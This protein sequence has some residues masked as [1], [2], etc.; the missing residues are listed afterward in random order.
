MQVAYWT[1]KVA[2]AFGFVPERRIFMFQN[3]F[4]LPDKRK[5]V[6]YYAL[7]LVLTL[8]ITAGIFAKNGWFPST[9]AISGKRTGWF[10]QTVAKNAPSSWNPLPLTTPTPGPPLAKEY[11]YAGSRLLA[12]EDANAT[13]VPPA[14]LAIFRPTG[15]EW[16]ILDGSASGSYSTYGALSWGLSGD[17]PV[18]GDYDGDGKTDFTIFRPSN[19][20]FWV[21]RSSEIATGG[22]MSESMGLTGDFPVSADVDGDGKTDFVLWRPSDSTWTIKQSSDGSTSYFG[23]ETGDKPAAGDF[24]GD[25][26]SD[27]AVW[28]DSNKTFYSRN[29]SNGATS[30]FT[31]TQSSTEPV[32]ADYDGDGK[33]DYAIRE[34]GTSNWVIRY[35]GSNTTSTISWQNASD[36]AV[37]N[38]YDGDGK[39]DIATWRDSNG[40]WY[41]RPSANPTTTRTVA[42]GMSG[43]WPVP[44]YFRR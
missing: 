34:S 25:G 22:H 3:E 15:A 28:R 5:K 43:D 33:A 26:K 41:I 11:I 13:A 14:D 31:F 40:T 17:I 37:Q 10:G 6:F 30:S 21:L 29:S 23:W 32:P 39:C 1:S 4:S 20:E 27:I 16:W 7:A 19:H 36:K 38:D 2:A 12:V 18:V 44:A 35:S 8:L 42:W 9:D 24:D